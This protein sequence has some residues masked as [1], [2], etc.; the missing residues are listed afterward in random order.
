MLQVFAQTHIPRALEEVDDHEQDYDR[1]AEGKDV[2]GIYYQTITGMRQDM[3]G[4]RVGPA[5]S[6]VRLQAGFH[7]L[8]LNHI[9]ACTL[10]LPLCIAQNLS[11]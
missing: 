7:D 4:A 9:A 8:H 3:T 11:L 5:F 6:Y 2:E 1:L 10:I